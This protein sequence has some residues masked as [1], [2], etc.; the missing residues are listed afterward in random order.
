MKAIELLPDL[1]LLDFPVGHAYLLRGS[2]GLTLIDSG[3]PGSAPRIA[4]AIEDLGYHRRDLRRLLLTH[5]HEDHIGSAAAVAAWGDVTVYAHRAD[6]PVIRGEAAGL[7]PKLLDW[8]RPLLAQV[9]AG[10]AAVP[11]PPVGVDQELTD[12]AVID[13]GGVAAVAIAVAGH[14]PG[15]V[16]FYLP[17][18]RV[19]FTGDTIARSRD[20]RVILGVFNVDPAQAVASFKRQAGLDLEVACFGHGEP[21]TANAGAMLRAAVEHLPVP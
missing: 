10:L 8:E 2:D 9:R 13:L 1:Y 12:G 3:V 16:A 5:H 18:L 21:L 11:A 15:S 6:A 20:G 17:D 19:L 4:A 7:P 14:T